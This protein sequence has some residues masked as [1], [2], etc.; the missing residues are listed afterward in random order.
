[1]PEG[2]AELATVEAKRP[3]TVDE[4]CGQLSFSAASQRPKDFN[5]FQASIRN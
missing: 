3:D 5:L 4:V 1:M 2:S